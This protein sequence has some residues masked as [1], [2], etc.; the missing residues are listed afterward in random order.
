VY[1]GPHMPPALLCMFVVT[2]NVDAH[3]LRAGF[4]AD[5]VRRVPWPTHAAGIALHG[6]RPLDQLLTAPTPSAPECWEGL[7][8]PDA[9]STRGPKALWIRAWATHDVD[10]PLAGAWV[11]VSYFEPGAAGDYRTSPLQLREALAAHTAMQK[12]RIVTLG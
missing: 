9:P 8:G 4:P 7:S 5:E 2:S 11:K 1:P 3:F 12:L 10:C 6:P